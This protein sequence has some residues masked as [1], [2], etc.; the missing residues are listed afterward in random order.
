VKDK[1]EK[2]KQKTHI[3]YIDHESFLLQIKD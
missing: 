1:A 3:R 2:K